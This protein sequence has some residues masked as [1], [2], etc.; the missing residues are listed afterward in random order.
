MWI[1]HRPT[2]G[3][4]VVMLCTI[5]HYLDYLNNVKN[6]HGGVLILVK[7]AALVKLTLLHERFSHFLNC[8]H[9]TKL[10]QASQYYNNYILVQFIYTC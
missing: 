8:T 1:A 5:Y 3:E 10:R 9:G 2:S 4:L 6:S 7:P